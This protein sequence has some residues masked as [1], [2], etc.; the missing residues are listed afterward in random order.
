MSTTDFA[1]MSLVDQA[2]DSVIL[3]DLIGPNGLMLVFY[4]GDW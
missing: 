1:A 4:R 2:G 3:S